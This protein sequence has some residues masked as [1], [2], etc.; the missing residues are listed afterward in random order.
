[1]GIEGAVDIAYREE[2]EAADDPEEKREELIEEFSERTN[3]ERAV[4]NVGVDA[5]IEPEE[6]R[7]VVARAIERAEKTEKGFPPKKHSINPM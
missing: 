7:G 3:A 1:M 4:E 5:A 2:I 6:T